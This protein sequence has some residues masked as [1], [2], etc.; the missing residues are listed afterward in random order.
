MVCVFHGPLARCVKL[1]VA[2]EPGMLGTLSPP[3]RVSDPDMHHGTCVT[4]VSWCMLGSLTS[5]FLWGRWRENV[6]GIPGACTTR[7]FT[8]LV[9]G[10][11]DT[12]YSADTSD[13]YTAYSNIANGYLIFF[14]CNILTVKPQKRTLVSNKIVENSRICWRWSN[15]ILNP[16]VTPDFNGLG[17]D[18]CKTSRETFTLGNWWGLYIMSFVE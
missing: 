8:Y 14:L 6:P 15:Y 18:K 10:P 16:D 12:L 17:N 7:N 13:K 4:H 1:W 2:H 3:L 11:W 5:G 9:R